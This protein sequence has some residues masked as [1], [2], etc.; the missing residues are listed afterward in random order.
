MVTIMQ[1]L[2]AA[3][4]KAVTLVGKTASGTIVALA[5]SNAKFV[6]SSDEA[7]LKVTGD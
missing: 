4:H 2:T 6:T 7:V 3:M 5:N 1:L